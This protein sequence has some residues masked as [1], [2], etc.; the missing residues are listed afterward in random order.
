MSNATEFLNACR[1]SSAVAYDCCKAILAD[2]ENPA[3]RT[4]TRRFLSKLERVLSLT[5]D[6]AESM[7][8]FHLALGKLAVGQLGHSRP[9]LTLLQ[10]PSVFAPEQ[11]SRTFFEGLARLPEIDLADRSLA[12]LGCGNG[13][14]SIALGLRSNAPLRIIGLDI[15]PR[16]ILSARINLYLNA[17]DADGGLVQDADGASLLDRVEFHESDLLAWV[18]EH[19][20][21]L[22]RVIGCIPQVLNPDIRN[23]H[24]VSDTDSDEFLVSLS[25]YAGRQGYLEDYFGLGL[26]ARAVEESIEVLRPGGRVVFNLGGRPGRKVLTDLLKRRGFEV[27]ELWTTRIKQAADTDIRTLAEIEQ[28]SN[29]RFEFF[30]GPYSDQSIDARTAHAYANAGGVVYHALSV[31]EGVLRFHESIRHVFRALHGEEWRLVR[32]AIDLN[33]DDSAVVEEKVAFLVQ[34]VDS[35]FTRTHFP[36]ESTVGLKKLREKMAGF[37]QEYFSIPLGPDSL[38]VAPDRATALRSFLELYRPALTL[39]NSALFE[40]LGRVGDWTA[41]ILEC[42]ARADVTCKLIETLRP[43]LVVT[44][45]DDLDIRSRDSFLRLIDATRAAG[46]R[47]VVDISSS[48]ELASNPSSNGVL[49]ELSEN[50]LP[51][52]VVIMCGLVRNRVYS[53]LEL[54]VLIAEN[55]DV[56]AALSNIAELTYSRTPLLTQEYYATILSALLGFRMERSEERNSTGLRFPD[57]ESIAE[58]TLPPIAP[59]CRAAFRHPS[60]VGEQLPRTSTT[61]RFDYGEN[62]LRSPRIVAASLF[63]AFASRE[64]N[65]SNVDPTTE[66]SRLL[67]RRFGLDPDPSVT[68]ARITFGL[69]VA[70]L[71]ADLVKA[72]VKENGTFIFPTG[73]YGNFVATVELYGGRWKCVETQLSNSFKMTPDELEASLAGVTYPWIYLNGPIVNP[74]GA[75]YSEDEVS[76]L[77]S[78]AARH[79]ACVVIDA[80]F[81]GLEYDKEVHWHLGRILSAHRVDLVVLGGISKELAAGGLRFGYAWCNSGSAVR[82]LAGRETAVPHRTLRLAARR[83]FAELNGSTAQTS[84]ELENQRA[85]LQRRA[86]ELSH[87]LTTC[88]WEVLAPRGGLFLVACPVQ[89]LGK[90][91]TAVTQSTRRD[92]VLDGENIAE[93]MF[94]AVDLQINNSK[95]TGIPN[96]CRFA[97]AVDDDSFADAL[98]RMAA[99]KTLV[100]G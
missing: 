91:F 52:H 44:T 5:Q 20:I 88:G 86:D 93:A 46:A 65:E 92:Y 34:L 45:L 7:Q 99:F 33:F 31:F 40:N 15:N 74:T 16:A 90:D 37:L 39:V 59:E 3:T 70:P 24:P 69:G 94:W 13:W 77:L 78:V 89:Y 12:E 80:I 82:T 10:L 11:W 49:Q 38:F 68:G 25:N 50:R 47:L 81:S 1:V 64:L 23:A 35:D 28:T 98:R 63:E 8:E 87:V 73:A 54:C 41:S 72:C 21:E 58:G 61:V 75:I 51:P 55:H 60:L 22:D 9:P 43:Q 67:S 2:L 53:D 79:N 76:Q 62:G 27:Q 32:S 6:P 18:R 57:A 29:H 100:L 96:Y 26:I 66:V 71:F 83:I 85:A 36:Y 48:F 19:E 4:R 30:L 97:F 95:W 42:P 17:L 14:I 56:L 84:V